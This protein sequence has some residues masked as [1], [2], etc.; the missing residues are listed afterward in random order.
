MRFIVLVLVLSWGGV[1]C[2]QETPEISDKQ[3]ADAHYQA[4]MQLYSEGRYKES[5]ASFDDAIA[6]SPDYVFFCNRAAVHLELGDAEKALPDMETCQRTFSGGEEERAI[7]DAQTKGVGLGVE[8]L[9]ANARNTTVGVQR[10]ILDSNTEQKFGLRGWG[11]VTLSVGAGAIGS[12]VVFD[13]LS[14][15]L[16]E[17]FVRESEGRSG[18]SVQEFEA[19]KKRVQTRQTVFYSLAITGAVLSTTGLAMIV[20]GGKTKEKEGSTRLLVTPTRV[21]VYGHF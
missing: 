7:I 3:R 2:A 1:V 17:H 11:L 21:S 4:A 18:T 12:A 14:A 9:I 19:L 8:N 16:V 20:F 13:L 15:D 5:L 10:A 6:L